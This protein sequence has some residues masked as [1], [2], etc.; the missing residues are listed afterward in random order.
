MKLIS[1]IK[2]FEDATGYLI[3]KEGILYTDNRGSRKVLKYQINHKGYRT[4]TLKTRKT[5][6]LHRLVALAFIPN[7]ENKEHVN[8]IDGNK[9][10]NHVSNLE[11]VT[12]SEN[13]KHAFATGLST[14]RKKELNYQY[15]GDHSNCKM[16]HQ[17]DMNGKYL[18]SHKSIALAS[19]SLGFERTNSSIG[20]CAN[21]YVK[22]AVGYLWSFKRKENY[23]DDI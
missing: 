15:T 20:K 17:Y 10:N 2:G 14:P 6:S 21:G 23:Y 4:V 9:E 13:N 18:T 8:H 11:W 12:A 3:S 16:L 19:R 1:E 5:I 22:Q 7:P